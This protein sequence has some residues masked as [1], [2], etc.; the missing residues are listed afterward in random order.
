M[1]IVPPKYVRER[2]TPSWPPPGGDGPFKFVRWRRDDELVLEANDGYWRGVPKV[3]TVV[4][5]PIPTESTRVAA[6]TRVRSTSRAGY[7]PASSS[8][9][10]TTPARA[11]QGASALNIHIVLDTLKD[12]PLKDRRV[13]Q[14][15]NY[16]V[17]KEGIIRS[18]LRGKRG[19]VGGPLT[20]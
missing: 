15:I 10:P 11:W 16:G 2:A 12:G 20:P 3:K 1:P 6:V 9:S 14:A 13:R 19:A 18:V 5:K 4:F 7:R 8:R 17:D